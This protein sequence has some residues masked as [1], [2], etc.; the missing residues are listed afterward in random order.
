HKSLNKHTMKTKYLFSTLVI[1]LAACG[2]SGLR[3]S[4]EAAE[5]GET[6]VPLA[7]TP[8]PVRQTIE[9]QLVGAQVEGIAMKLLQGK[10]VYETDIIRDG[11]KWELLVAEDGSIIHNVQEGSAEEK[12]SEKEAKPKKGKAGWR[13]NFE[14]NKAALAATGN[15]S[16]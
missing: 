8:A 1:A 3:S 13:D 10:T 7:Q 9:S 12:E 14:V 11:H 4:E 5:P 15:H 16:Y 6:K 2:C